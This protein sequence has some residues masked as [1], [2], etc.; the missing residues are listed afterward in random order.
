MNVHITLVG[1]QPAPVYHGIVA[2]HPDRVVYVYSH[3]SSKELAAIRAE[4]AIQEDEYPALDP[5]DIYEITDRAKELAERYR[6]DEV[7]VNISGGT[8]AWTFIFGITFQSMP[9]AHVIYFDQNNVLWDYRDMSHRDD[10][11]FDM[12]ALFRL[13]GNPLERYRS[14]NEYDEA[15]VDV[16][17]QIESIINFQR[18]H[19]L[20]LTTVLNKDWSNRLVQQNAGTFV[21]PDSPSFVEWEKGQYARLVLYHNKRG[22]Q[23]TLFRSPHAVELLFNSGWFEFKVARILHGWEY[24]QEIRLNC[25]FPPKSD[26]SERRFRFPKNEIDII[27]N[28]GRKIL[29]VECKTHINSSNDI[30]KFK[31]AV[32]N[33]G[34]RASKALFVTNTRMDDKQIE[35]CR[36]SGIVPFFLEGGGLAKEQELYG[37]LDRLILKINA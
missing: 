6:D 10:F 14:Y 34:G 1:G 13:H 12:D 17:R 20:S 16:V 5:I 3:D 36:E 25:I 7:T 29:F 35:K 2:T 23:D 24:A 9:N 15:D 30:D 27:V 18:K 37:I 33:Y 8:K 21:L 19:F 26:K 31:N 4:V 32:N 28:T 11:Q 22:V